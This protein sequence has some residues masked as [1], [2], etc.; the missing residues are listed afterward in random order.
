MEAW[1][2]SLN[3]AMSLTEKN[4]NFVNKDYIISKQ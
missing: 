2:K 4:T 1:S 3:D